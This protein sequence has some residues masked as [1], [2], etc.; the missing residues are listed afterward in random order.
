MDDPYS[1]HMDT[2][3]RS[4]FANCMVIPV[5]YVTYRDTNLVYVCKKSAR[6]QDKALY[7]DDLNRSTMEHGLEHAVS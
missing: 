1:K 6:E 2:T 7:T 5:R 4:I 3:I